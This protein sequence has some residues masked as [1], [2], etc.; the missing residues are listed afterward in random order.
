M[1][2]IYPKVTWTNIYKVSFFKSVTQLGNRKLTGY[3]T[4]YAC[5]TT[6]CPLKRCIFRL[7]VYVL[8][9]GNLERR[10]QSFW[11]GKSNGLPSRVYILLFLKTLGTKG[12]WEKFKHKENMHEQKYGSTREHVWALG[13]H[14]QTALCEFKASL[15]Y[16]LKSRPGNTT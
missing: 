16:S 10:S 3:I 2:L 8:C 6:S 7:I 9:F 15:I 4:H 13:R 12:E 11:P 14:S 1:T 5:L